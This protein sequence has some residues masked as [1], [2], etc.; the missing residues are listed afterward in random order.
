MTVTDGELTDT[1]SLVVTINNIN[2][3]TP[4]FGSSTYTFYAQPNTGVGTVLG[5]VAATDG[6]VGTFGG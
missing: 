6:D 1:A 3:N 5:S 2:D 4:T